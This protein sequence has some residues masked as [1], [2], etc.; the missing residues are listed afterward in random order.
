M[1]FDITNHNIG[2]TDRIIRA[3]IGALLIIGTLRGGNWIAGLIGAILLGTAYFRFC[4]AYTIFDFSTNNDTAPEN[5][6]VSSDL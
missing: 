3:I 4:P 2:K 1:K 5:K 6:Q